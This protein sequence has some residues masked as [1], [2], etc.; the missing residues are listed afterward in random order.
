MSR[1]APS[2]LAESSSSCAIEVALP[3]QPVALQG[4]AKLPATL[5][6]ANENIPTLPRRA[7]MGRFCVADS[8]ADNRMAL[9]L[10]WT[11]EG[12]WE[13]FERRIEMLGLGL[14]GTIIVV[15]LIVWL[16]RRV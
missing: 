12:Q 4:E 10:Q 1:T 5:I 16:I 14:L 3:V 11:G 15:V 13:R 9:N 7:D 6:R 2:H 8:R